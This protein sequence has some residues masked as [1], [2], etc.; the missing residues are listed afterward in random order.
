MAKLTTTTQ[1]IQYTLQQQQQEYLNEKEKREIKRQYKAFLKATI[2]ENLQY[3]YITNNNYKNIYNY[4]VLNSDNI[5]NKIIEEIEEENEQQKKEIYI[6]E[7]QNDGS[8]K[9]I[10]TTIYLWDDFDIINDIDTL[11][12]KV[13]KQVNEE[14][15]LKKSV[16]LEQLTNDLKNDIRNTFTKYSFDKVCLFATDSNIIHEICQNLA[17][18]SEEYLFLKNNYLKIF[19]NISNEYKK[20]ESYKKTNAPK[21][22]TTYKKPINNFNNNSKKI[23]KIGGSAIVA[24]AFA[25]FCKG[26]VNASKNK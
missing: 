16:R 1:E 22:I 21:Q 12:F 4:I 9:E 26:L 5:K 10:K 23:N 25:G 14:F 20:I 15:K 18:N 19:Y 3:Y 7:K 17:Q 13:L 8:Y 2:K 24:S 6:F 11:F